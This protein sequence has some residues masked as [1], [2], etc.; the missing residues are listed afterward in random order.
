ML[1]PFILNRPQYLSALTAALQDSGRLPVMVS[2]CAA[3]TAYHVTMAK[4][5]IRQVRE[6]DNDI[7]WFEFYD[8]C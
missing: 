5:V 8:Q 1:C 6:H 4:L 2:L 7:I 3:L